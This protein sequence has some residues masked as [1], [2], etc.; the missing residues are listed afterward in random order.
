MSDRLATTTTTTTTTSTATAAATATATATTTTA[1]YNK[2]MALST[3]LAICHLLNLLAEMCVM[4]V[5]PR[6]VCQ[7]SGHKARQEIN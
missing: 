6:S 2:L 5:N 3:Y 1:M 7:V 4:P